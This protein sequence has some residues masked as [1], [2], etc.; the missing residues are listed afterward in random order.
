MK[1]TKLKQNKKGGVGDLFIWLII[2][3]VIIIVL[4][5]FYFM[6]NT[7]N[8]EMKDKIPQLQKS[9]G[10]NHNATE[11]VEQSIG[12]IPRAFESFKWISVMLMVGMLLSIVLGGFL[13]KVHPAFFVTCRA[14]PNGADACSH[15]FPNL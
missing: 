3:F 2:S 1:L 11:I 15:N 13:V 4:G 9:L 7:I 5:A 10:D 6:G 12:A 8:D 14:E